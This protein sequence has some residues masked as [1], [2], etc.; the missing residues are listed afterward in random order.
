M[1]APHPH[2]LCASA[3]APSAR[4]RL[5]VGTPLFPVTTPC[6]HRTSVP[7]RIQLTAVPS[8]RLR[9]CTRPVSASPLRSLRPSVPPR[10]HLAAA[11]SSRG[12]PRPCR[13]ARSAHPSPCRHALR[14]ASST[15]ARQSPV[16]WHRRPIPHP[17]TPLRALLLAHLCRSVSIAQLYPPPVPVLLPDSGPVKPPASLARQYARCVPHPSRHC[18]RCRVASPMRHAPCTSLSVRVAPRHAG[19]SC[20]APSQHLSTTP[21]PRIS[22]VYAPPTALTA[23]AARVDRT[24]SA[25]SP[26]SL[27]HPL[28]RC[29]R[30]G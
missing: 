5:R 8:P 29:V 26:P 7:S 22:T 21:S 14:P 12:L 19:L 2:C 28:S 16:H 4:K 3:S 27:L 30:I 1:S 17:P 24:T 15:G 18:T 9:R 11:P 23:A 6:P 10:V 13:A 20:A 25:L